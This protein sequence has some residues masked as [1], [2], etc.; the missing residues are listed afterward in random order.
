[1]KEF[2]ACAL[3]SATSFICAE[4]AKV[5]FGI[6]LARLLMLIVSGIFALVTVAL[7]VNETARATVQHV[8]DLRYAWFKPSIDF[9]HSLRGLPP[10]GM[11][12]VG[13]F[14]F[15]EISGLLGDQGLLWTVRFA[16]GDVELEL[17]RQFLVMSQET[18]P[19]L[20]PIREHGHFAFR[21][22]V[23]VEAKLTILTNGI[24]SRGWAD[25]SAGPFPTKLK[26]GITVKQLSDI[27]EVNL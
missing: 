6:E 19:F 14:S 23:D 22:W 17:I 27:F 24:I 4:I 13:K 21:D 16:G 10:Y 26:E 9:A 18:E 3:I 25:R 12:L 1:L 15:L 5:Y 7:G 20:F 11:E 2:I 8:K